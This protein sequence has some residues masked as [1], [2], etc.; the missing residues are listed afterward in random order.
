MLNKLKYHTTKHVLKNLYHTFIMPYVNYNI[1]NW[2]STSH[3]NIKPLVLIIKKAVRI[4]DSKNKYE[5]TLPIFKNLRIL[6][7]VEQIKL[8]QGHFM[9][10]LYNKRI[11]IPID[12]LF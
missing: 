2:S 12:G 5:H 4:I 11:R 9:W 1:L 7:L 6:P 8:N 3:T 10:K